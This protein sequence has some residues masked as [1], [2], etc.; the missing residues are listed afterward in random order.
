MARTPGAINLKT[1]ETLAAFDSFVVK[2]KIDP[3]E[4]MFMA[5]K[6]SARLFKGTS[7]S[8]EEK[9]AVRLT[10][11][12]ELLPYGHAKL[13]TIKHV[14]VGDPEMELVWQ[15]DLFQPEHTPQQ[16]LSDVIEAL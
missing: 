1:S 15:G 7:Y 13:A 14:A 12:K 11:A 2:Y 4:I 9:L 6:G 8:P 3:L 5:C 10:A 16:Q